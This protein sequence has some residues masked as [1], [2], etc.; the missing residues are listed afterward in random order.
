MWLI[1]DCGVVVHSGK[2][3]LTTKLYLAEFRAGVIAVTRTGDSAPRRY[4]K[5]LGPL[6]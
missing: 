4:R 1:S 5:T 3:Y 2:I 6:T